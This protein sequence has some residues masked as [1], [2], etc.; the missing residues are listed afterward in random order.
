MWTPCCLSLLRSHYLIIALRRN[1]PVCSLDV[2]LPGSPFALAFSAPPALPCCLRSSSPCLRLILYL[3]TWGTA[4]A[5]YISTCG[6]VLALLLWLFS[7]CCTYLDER[8]SIDSYLPRTP[9]VFTVRWT[10]SNIALLFP[11]ICRNRQGSFCHWIS[12]LLCN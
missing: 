11:A 12:L 8:W 2:R 3:T 4:I 9:V 1:I 5:F 10:S 7:A 6:T